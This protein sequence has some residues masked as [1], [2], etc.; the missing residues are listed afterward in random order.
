MKEEIKEILND[1]KRLSN[2]QTY[3][4]DV[5]DYETAKIFLDY[6]TNLQDENERLKE[7]LKEI[8]LIFY[9]LRFIDFLDQDTHIETLY[10]IINDVR[11]I[12]QI[13][14]CQHNNIKEVLQCYIE[15]LVKLRDRLKED[16]NKFEDIKNNLDWLEE[17]FNV[18]SKT[19]FKYEVLTLYI[20]EVLDET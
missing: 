2:E 17:S 16:L 6:I 9:R 10:N 5:I 15:E 7:C 18:K 20:K 12:A 1:L 19:H 14:N 13:M 3:P 8:D 11:Q 4:E